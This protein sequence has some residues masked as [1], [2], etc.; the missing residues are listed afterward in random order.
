MLSPSV[1]S[2]LLMVRPVRFGFNEQTATNNAFQQPSANA[3]A[4][5]AVAAEAVHE[6]DAF[7]SLLRQHGVSVDVLQ[8]TPEPAT[9]DSIFPNNCFST[10]TDDHG[11][12]LVLYPMYAPNR[13]LERT[14]LRTLLDTFAFDRV[15]DLT[16]WEHREQYL[17]GTGSLVLDRSHRFA[18]ACRSPRTSEAVLSEWAE[19][20]GYDYLLFDSIDAAGTPVYHTNVVMHVGIRQA[21]VCLDSIPDPS[22]RRQLIDKLEVL[23]KEFVPITLDQMN[24]FAGNM[25]EVTNAHAASL[26]V[27]S[28]TAHGSLT[29]A[30]LDTLSRTSTLI[31]PNIHSIET[32]GG[33][34]ARCMMA[35]LWPAPP[36]PK[37][38][39][40]YP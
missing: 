4:A 15:L 28:T 39:S 34:S 18:F 13:R 7:V 22:Q 30:Q 10:H 37:G 27:M 14:K 32:A 5:E 26:L 16:A 1:T 3:A 36:L 40:P 35:E 21:V 19:A 11:T 33:G 12:T 38:G 17:E 8:D 2:R 31:T 25:L 6:F 9:P 23:G 20:L 24:R 29:A